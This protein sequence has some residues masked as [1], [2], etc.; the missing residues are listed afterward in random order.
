MVF[1]IV[2]ISTTFHGQ[3][4]VGDREKGVRS[5]LNFSGLRPSAY[6]L[7]IALAESLI[8]IV[9]NALLVLFSGLLG[10][11]IFFKAGPQ[12]MLVIVFLSLPLIF[13]S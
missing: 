1:S 13:V 4:T 9:T 5:L 7:G 11:E 3:I 8:F 2:L 6:Y 12:I 10:I